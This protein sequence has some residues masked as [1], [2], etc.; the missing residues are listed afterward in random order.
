MSNDSQFIIMLIILMFLNKLPMVVDAVM[1]S[2]SAARKEE[3][4]A[5]E[6]EIIECDHTRNLVQ[7][8]SKALES[9]GT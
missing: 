2:V 6:E 3:I 8:S 1:A 9:K 5:W 4:K 7:N